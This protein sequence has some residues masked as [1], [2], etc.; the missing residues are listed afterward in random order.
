[1]LVIGKVS[2][3]GRVALYHVR[4]LCFFFVA[5]RDS[6]M[7]LEEVIEGKCVGFRRKSIV[8]LHVISEDDCD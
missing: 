4:F 2:N 3:V 1:M 5:K 7:A 8:L 6:S